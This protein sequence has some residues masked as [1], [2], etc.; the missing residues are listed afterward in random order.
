MLAQ[1][2]STPVYVVV[3]R[4]IARLWALAMFL[5]WG[6][7]FVEHLE[8]FTD[9]RGW[10]PPSVFALVSLHF[11]MLVGLALGW[12][13]E[14]LGGSLALVSAIVFFSLAA[15]ANA[16]V[17]IATIAVPAVLWLY[18][19][20]REHGPAAPEPAPKTVPV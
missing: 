6:A 20:W 17:F 4:W 10:P 9:P 15:G 7:F 16:P 14:V 13:W 2:R 8:W 18:C 19:A 3:L 5:L 12:R 11:L 1:P